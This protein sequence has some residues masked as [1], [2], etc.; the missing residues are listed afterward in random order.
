MDFA[1]KSATRTRAS[2]VRRLDVHSGIVQSRCDILVLAPGGGPSR[3]G[4]RWVRGGDTRPFS[5]DERMTT[6]GWNGRPWQ[7][8][9][10]TCG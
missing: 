5:L 7:L 8:R 4:V 10:S 2:H 6:L 3:G 1:A 9:N